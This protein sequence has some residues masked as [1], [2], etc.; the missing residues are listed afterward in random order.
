MYKVNFAT[1][2]QL[3]VVTLSKTLQIL[4]LPS[5]PNQRSGQRATPD[6]IFN[7][8]LEPKMHFYHVKSLIERRF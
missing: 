6:K 8:I 7:K 2:L 4:I 3:S 1:T 5:Y